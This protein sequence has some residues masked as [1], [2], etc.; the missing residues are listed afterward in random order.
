MAVYEA[1]L[2]E[3][4]L[5]EKS[6]E[7]TIAGRCCESGDLIAKDISLP[8]VEAGELLAVLATGAYN[9][10]MASNYKPRTPPRRRHGIGRRS[11]TR[12]PAGDL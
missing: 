4:P 11:E 9:Y 5:D 10:S 12:R 2:P 3:R 7:V 8:P 1:L 6:T